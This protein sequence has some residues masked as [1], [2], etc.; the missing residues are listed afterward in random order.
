[1]EHGAWSSASALHVISAGGEGSCQPAIEAVLQ[2]SKCLSFVL[3]GPQHLSRVGD[4]VGAHRG[5]LTRRGVVWLGTRMERA[6][7]CGGW[8]GRL[9]QREG[10]SC[11]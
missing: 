7:A 8:Q 10:S 4:Q 1:M 9:K 6:A 2:C 11:S 5:S 3:V